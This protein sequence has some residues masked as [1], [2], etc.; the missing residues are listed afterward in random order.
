[1]PLPLPPPP[2]TT[3]YLPPPLLPLFPRP[4][5]ASFLLYILL[6][7]LLLSIPLFLLPFSVL[8][9]V[10]RRRES[11]GRDEGKE[12]SGEGEV[13]LNSD[14]VLFLPSYLSF[15]STSLPLFPVLFSFK[16]R[17]FTFPFPFIVFPRPKYPLPLFLS[18]YKI[19]IHISFILFF[20]LLSFFIHCIL[21]HFL[22]IFPF[23]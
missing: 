8:V 7:F 2:T 4:P 21:A 13:N 15:P 17:P 3:T 16:S 5:P 23:P 1:M 22:I 19:L 10:G 14:S 20:L 12:G 18:C 6:P 11:G 9:P